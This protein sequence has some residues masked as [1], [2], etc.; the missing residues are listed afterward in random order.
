MTEDTVVAAEGIAVMYVAG[1]AGRPISEHVQETR[2]EDW[3]ATGTEIL[4]RGGR[5]G[6]PGLRRARRLPRR[7]SPPWP[8]QLGSC[9][10]AR[11]MF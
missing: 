3:L 5:Q 11:G 2:G 8:W 1:A 4:W 10:G 7:S 6:V 9:D